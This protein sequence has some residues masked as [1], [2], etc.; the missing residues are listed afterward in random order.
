MLQCDRAQLR[1]NSATVA[2]LLQ[3]QLQVDATRHAQLLKQ[4]WGVNGSVA[5][6]DLTPVLRS[7]RQLRGFANGQQRPGLSC[8]LQQTCCPAVRKAKEKGRKEKEEQ[9][10]QNQSHPRPLTSRN[11]GIVKIAEA[12]HKHDSLLNT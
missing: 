6:G 1:S 8:L 11:C 4:C 2:H 7:W 12:H 3:N 5:Q 9:I 10:R